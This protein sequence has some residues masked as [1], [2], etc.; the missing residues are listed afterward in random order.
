M[1]F[2]GDG[3]VARQ[4][5][6]QRHREHRG[7]SVTFVPLWLPGFQSDPT[8][9]CVDGIEPTHGWPRAIP[10]MASTKPSMALPHAIDAIT[11][12][13]DGITPCHRCHQPCHRWHPPMP[14]MVLTHAI[15]AIDHAID[16]IEHAVNNEQTRHRWLESLRRCL[17]PST[18]NPPVVTERRNVHGRPEDPPNR[19]YHSRPCE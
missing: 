17:P 18:P 16:G 10:S 8:H 15:D 2:W 7:L 14:S 13:I 6:P 11:L 19:G 4:R 5:Q 9:V 1:V 12:A 3:V